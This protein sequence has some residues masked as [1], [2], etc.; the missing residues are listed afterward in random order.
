[1]VVHPIQTKRQPETNDASERRPMRCSHHLAPRRSQCC[2]RI[3]RRPLAVSEAGK[4]G[5]KMVT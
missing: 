3:C 4:N 5:S 2:S 1:M